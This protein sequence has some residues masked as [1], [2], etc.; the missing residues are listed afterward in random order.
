M[1]L[2]IVSQ[3][4]GVYHVTS[5]HLIWSDLMSYHVLACNTIPLLQHHHPHHIHFAHI[6]SNAL[7]LIV[8]I[9]PQSSVQHLLF[10]NYQLSTFC[11]LIIVCSCRSWE[12]GNPGPVLSR[13]LGPDLGPD[14]DPLDSD[15]PGDD[16]LTHFGVGWIGQWLQRTLCV[17]WTYVHTYVWMLRCKGRIQG[18]GK[19]VRVR[20]TSIIKWRASALFNLQSIHLIH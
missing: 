15:S 6:S 11:S 10:T 19:F 9:H 17:I 4:D 5:S 12:G 20:V 2:L 13:E 14:S 8:C 16:P 1:N 7:S 3:T 18:G